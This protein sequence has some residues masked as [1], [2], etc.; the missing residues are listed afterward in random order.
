MDTYISKVERKARALIRKGENLVSSNVA[1]GMVASENNNLDKAEKHYLKAI[2]LDEN[3]AEA[4][5]GLGMVYSKK[6]K[7][8]DAITN[9]KKSLELSPNCGLLANWIADAYFDMGKFEEA[10]EYYNLSTALN[11]FDSNAYNDL[12][13]TYRLKGD[14]DKALESYEKALEIDPFDTNAMLE[15]AQCLFLKNKKLAG[16]KILD[17]IIERHSDT[18]DSGTAASIAATTYS[19][20]G[21]HSKAYK[22]FNMALEHFQF[23]TRILFHLALTCI[24][25][26]KKNEAIKF[27]KKIPEIDPADKKSINLLRKL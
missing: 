26:N 17:M 2:K 3:C 8:E 16:L 6:G 18:L 4:Y 12:A 10:V 15:K 21:E 25:L 27:L 11:R 22:Y 14:I 20:M 24:S 7:T 5:A 1:I 9:Y 19:Q 13:D 23:N